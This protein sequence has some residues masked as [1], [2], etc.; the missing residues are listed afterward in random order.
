[1]SP[2]KYGNHGMRKRHGL[3]A[4]LTGLR[5]LREVVERGTFSA[6]AL[7]LGYTQSAV[8]RQIAAVERAA[9]AAVFERGR[10]GACRRRRAG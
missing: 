3:H 10:D 2:R 5:V 8:S 7:A 9:G 4:L 1:M 6:A